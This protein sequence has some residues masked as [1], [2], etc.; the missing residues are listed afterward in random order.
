[1]AAL[2]EAPRGSDPS[3][4][5]SPRW[6]SP[7]RS[8]RRRVRI[9]TETRALQLQTHAAQ[10]TGRSAAWHR[11]PTAA[12]APK[13]DARRLPDSDW[14]SLCHVS[15]SASLG[16]TLEPEPHRIKVSDGLSLGC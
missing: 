15:C 10:R 2:P 7:R 3:R 16:R 9:R 5:G 6:R 14:N 13:V 12:E 8:R 4:R 11:P 1:M